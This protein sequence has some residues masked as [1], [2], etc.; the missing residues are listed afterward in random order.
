MPAW[1]DASSAPSNSSLSAA[2]A[3]ARGEPH[4][5]QRLGHDGR[6]FFFEQLALLH[7]DPVPQGGVERAEHLAAVLLPG[8]GADTHW[9]LGLGHHGP[10]LL[11]E[12]GPPGVED[13]Q[14]HHVPLDADRAHLLDL[15][16]PA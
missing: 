16:H 5:G 2:P 6:A 7:V 3:R 12:L 9:P 11:G 13:G 1:C 8:G 10:V 4:L 15:G 14:G